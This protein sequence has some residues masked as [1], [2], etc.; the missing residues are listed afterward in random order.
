MTGKKHSGKDL[1]IVGTNKV[2]L[3]ATASAEQLVKTKQPKDKDLKIA[4][5]DTTSLRTP[6][7]RGTKSQI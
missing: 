1:R 7:N 2:R 5:V 4:S 3:K 6:N